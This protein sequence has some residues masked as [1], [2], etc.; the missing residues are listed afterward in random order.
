MFYLQTYQDQVPE[1][2]KDAESHQWEKFP[3][4]EHCIEKIIQS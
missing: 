3:A 4:F 1:Q 2:H